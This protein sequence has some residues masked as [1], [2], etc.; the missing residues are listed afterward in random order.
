ML[1]ILC[2]LYVSHVVN[3]RVGSA[4]RLALLD[5]PLL[6][7]GALLSDYTSSHNGSLLFEGNNRTVFYVGGKPSNVE[8]SS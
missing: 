2:T 5:E 4:L 8:V 3:F 6:S 7:P 1:L